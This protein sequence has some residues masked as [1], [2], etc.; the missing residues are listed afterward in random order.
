MLVAPLLSA[1]ASKIP[2]RGTFFARPGFIDDQIASV[3]IL[4][5][6][7]INCLLRFLR[8]AHCDKAKSSRTLSHFVHDEH[9]LSHR[10]ELGEEFFERSFSGLK[11]EI[12][13]IQ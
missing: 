11:G 9:G 3:D 1:T 8:A 5:I 13:Y 10:A 4:A 7:G 6:E 12:S 2:A